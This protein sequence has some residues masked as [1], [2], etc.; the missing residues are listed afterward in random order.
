MKIVVSTVLL[1]LVAISASSPVSTFL[2]DYDRSMFQNGPN[3]GS[4]LTG[5]S[6]R[7]EQPQVE[8]NFVSTKLVKFVKYQKYQK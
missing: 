7:L 4:F 6:Y 2:P 8:N 1:A 3:L 5:S